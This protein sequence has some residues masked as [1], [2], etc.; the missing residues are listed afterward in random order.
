MHRMNFV[1]PFALAFAL[2][3]AASPTTLAFQETPP[4][5]DAPVAAGEQVPYA[6]LLKAKEQILA[7]EDALSRRV[8]DGATPALS[9]E[10]RAEL[11]QQL[12]TIQDWFHRYADIT[13]ASKI[14][15]LPAMSSEETREWTMSVLGQQAAEQIQS[16]LYSERRLSH[17]SIRA[18]GLQGTV[19]VV[20]ERWE[21]DQVAAEVLERFVAMRDE[22]RAAAAARRNLDERAAHE[23]AQA[24]ERALYNTTVNIRWAGGRLADLIAEVQKGVSCNVVLGDESVGNLVVPA[25]SVDFVAPAPFFRM[26]NSMPLRE[27]ADGATAG[28]SVI[29]EQPT[30]ETKSGDAPATRP[31]ILIRRTAAPVV[32][33]SSQVFDLSGWK[34]SD[35]AGIKA[36]V[37]AVNFALE[38]DGTAQSVTVRYHKPSKLLFAKGP[39]RAVGLVGE[40]VSTMRNR[41]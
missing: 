15:K 31:V 26:L 23:R 19:V 25:L 22:V 1:H 13:P 41:G 40:V 29:V 38:S 9:P 37:E 30:Q 35:D 21:L 2:V 6:E 17:L 33:S 27:A 3:A 18:H 28:V 20:A 8:P 10:R 14:V 34:D 32:D 5:P 4:K 24:A 36:L 16:E 12:K 39:A 11:Q 7:L